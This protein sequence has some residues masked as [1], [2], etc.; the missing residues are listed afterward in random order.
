MNSPTPALPDVPAVPRRRLHI[1][2]VARHRLGRV[3]ERLAPEIAAQAEVSFVGHAFDDA[4]AAV[5]ALHARAPID[6]VVAAGASGEWLRQH[7][8]LPVAIVEVRGFDLMRALASARALSTRVGLVSFDGPSEHLAQLDTLFGMGIAQFSYRGPD[9]APACVEALRAAGVEAVVAPGLVA[10][11][12]EQAGIASVLMYSDDAVRQALQDAVHMARLGRAERAR[13]ERLGTILGQLQDGVVA[14]DLRQRI[15]ALNPVMA[16]LL[17]GS[18]AALVGRVLGDVEP[19]LDLGATLRMQEAPAEE[20]LQIGMRTLVVRRA[21]I[22]EGGEVT[23]ALLVCRDPAVIQRADRH[24]RANQRQRGAPA[25]YRIEA[26]AGEG[27]AARRVR[28]L[29]ARCAASDATV[30]ITGESGTGKELVAQGIH[31]ASR[32]ATQPFLAVN[33]AALA[34]SLLESELFGHEEGAFTGARRGGKTGLIEAAHTGTL[35]LDEIGDMPLALQTR[36]LRVLQEREVLRLGATAAVPVDLRVIAATH[37]DL[38]AQ[39]E[40]GLFR[41]DLYYRLAVLRIETPPLR[42]RGTDI[43]RLASALMARRAAALGVPDGQ[44]AAGLA[45]LMALA[46]G[47]AWPG[48]VRELENLVERL[49]AC[50]DL[51][52]AGVPDRARL[53][54]MFPECSQARPGPV[55]DGLLKGARRAAE[56]RRVREVLQSVQGDQGQ[57]CALLGISRATL[58]RRLRDD[59]SAAGDPGPKKPSA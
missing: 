43:A 35:F 6:A 13:H 51:A 45:A 14:V 28:E 34:E 53:L 4:V 31:T 18:V 24:L 8:D 32:R 55:R 26:F 25:R 54:E 16:E 10:D 42:D 1:V 17:G 33:C 48:N 15:E 11:L 57:A 3:L 50:H 29:A 27:A 36:L 44:A 5:R 47:Y 9:D 41:R 37:A 56:L 58:W 20:V 2:A 7:L 52:P 23:G 46:A 59:A 19:V 21:P 12:A 22:V 49:L 40:R 30:L 39:V 38:A